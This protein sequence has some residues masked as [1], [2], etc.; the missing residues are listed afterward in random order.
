[1][2]G[3]LVNWLKARRSLWLALVPALA[4]W[5]LGVLWPERLG[6]FC[7]AGLGW[8]LIAQFV[9]RARERMEYQVAIRHMRHGDYQ[10]AVTVVDALIDAQPDVAEHRRFRAEL[11]R[12]F[13]HLQEAAADYER[14]VRLDPTSPA[15]HLG[16]AE[17]Y[18]QQGIYERALDYAQ[19]ALERDPRGWKAAYN[20]GLIEDRLEDAEEAITHLELA[21]SAGIPHR[22][23][24]LLARL[25]LAR[26]HYRRGQTE[27]ARQQLEQMREQANGL[28]DWQV[29]FE[30]EHSAALRALLE[31]DVTLAQRLLC[32]QAS[33][34]ALG[35]T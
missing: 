24:R 21:L 31:A 4:L 8:V 19:Q 33:L 9:L 5:S 25:W 26:N 7:G 28:R 18:A 15:G 35:G 13:G 34:D 11:H 27:I 1:M 12:L 30:N 20:L 2:R 22:R 14:M 16:L 3:R 23:Y 6:F 10:Q 32:E 29:I 17:V